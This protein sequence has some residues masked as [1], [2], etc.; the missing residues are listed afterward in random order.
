MAALNKKKAEELDPLKTELENLSTAAMTASPAEKARLRPRIQQL[1]EQCGKVCAEL[2]AGWTE[3]GKDMDEAQAQGVFPNQNRPQQQP[4]QQPPAPVDTDR[5]ERER[6]LASI[7]QRRV[8]IE[9]NF[10]SDCSEEYD[11][12]KRRL[13][14]VR[15]DP[16][17][18]DLFSSSGRAN[19]NE[20]ASAN[21][22]AAE[23]QKGAAG[24]TPQAEKRRERLNALEQERRQIL[25]RYPAPGDPKFIE[26]QGM[27]VTEAEKKKL[28]DE[29]G[30]PR[31]ACQVVIK[32]LEQ[33]GVVH[34][35]TYTGT[36]TDPESK[37]WLLVVYSGR[38]GRKQTPFHFIVREQGGYWHVVENGIDKHGQLL[39]TSED[40]RPY[41]L[42]PAPRGSRRIPE[43]PAS[44]RGSTPPSPPK[45][46]ADD[47][48][49]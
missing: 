8:E 19:Y 32:V 21:K 33:K 4:T 9:K 29:H 36:F 22:R 26:Q 20:M 24:K 39:R 11:R 6:L 3:L 30:S 43:K 41:G 17:F 16:S 23:L 45:K 2:D 49:E 44:P 47:T 15:A 13:A 27:L 7:E 42:G 48:T 28:E 1:I 18:G 40:D 38:I 37:E 25:T 14:A 46:A 5:A 12:L 31:A 34:N 35:P 10:L